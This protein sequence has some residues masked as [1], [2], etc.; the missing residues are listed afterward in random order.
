MTAR[1]SLALLPLLLAACS[2]GPTVTPDAG[3]AP[4]SGVEPHD[5]GEAPHDAGEAPHDAGVGPAACDPALSV[6]RAQVAVKALDLF[7]IVASGGTGAYRFTLTQ[8]ASGAIVNALSGAYL[9]GETTGVEDV[10]TVTDDGCEGS[11]QVTLRV[12]QPLLLRPTTVMATP[13]T[14]WRFEVEGG[15]GRVAFAMDLAGSGGAVTEAGEYTAG[16]SEGLDRV[17]V[18]DLES[19]E[20]AEAEVTVRADARMSVVPPVVLVPMGQPFTLGFSGGS[21]FV[22]IVETPTRFALQGGRTVVGTAPGREQVTARD[23]FTGETTT[24]MVGVGAPHRFAPVRSGDGLF[25]A[26]M[27][28]PGDLDG[29]GFPDVLLAQPEADVG[30]VNS[31]AVYVYRGSATGVAPVAAQVLPGLDRRE[32][33]GRAMAVADFDHDGRLDLAVGAPRA[34]SAGVD[35]GVVRIYR[36]AAAGLFEAQPWLTLPG[37]FAADNFGWALAACDFNDDGHMDLAVGSFNSE[38]RD[39]TPQAGNQGGVAI[40]FGHDRGLPTEATRTLWG[41]LPDGSGGWVGQANLHLGIALAAG[42]VDGDGVC[43]LVAGTYE[44]DQDTN[45]NDGL[46]YVYR[47]LRADGEAIG[48]P[49]PRPALAWANLDP[50]DLGGSLARNLAVAD[51]DGDDRAEVIVSHHGFDAGSGDSHGALRVFRGQPM[52]APVSALSPARPADWQYEHDGSADQVGFYPVVADATGDGR[53]DLLVGNLADEATGAPADS[54]TVF[55]FEGR[56]AALPETTPT[57][58]LPGDLAG[59]R[60]GTALTV[61][62]DLDGDRRPEWVVLAGY[63]DLYGPDYGVPLYVPGDAAAPRAPLELESAA[64]GAQFGWDAAVVGD[65]T[66]DGLEDLVVGA[67]ESGVE[68]LGR[69]TG[70]AYLYPGAADGFATEPALSLTQALR[71]SA[72]DRFGVGVAPAGDFDGDGTPDFAVV[73]RFEDQPSSFGSTYAPEASCAGAGTDVG[74]VYVFSGVTSG[75][76]SD[77]PIFL[78]F[79]PLAGDGLRAIDGGFDYDGDGFDD[80]ILGNLEFDPAGGTNAGGVL[81]IRGRARDAQG[82]TV[83]RCAPDFQLMGGVANDQLGLAVTAV[84]D[85]DGDGCDEVAAGA[86]FEDPTLTN[87]GTVRVIFGWGGAGCPA[88]PQMVVLRAGLANA[89]GGRGLGG[90]GD[91]D[92]D[93]VPD[94]AVGLPGFAQDGNTVGAAGLISGAYVVGLPRE[95]AQDATPPQRV[96]LMFDA[97]RPPAVVGGTTPGEELGRSA[98][99]VDLGAP[100]G[101]VVVAGSPSGDL[102]GTTLAGGARGFAWQAGVGLVAAPLLGFAGEPARP[103][104]RLGEWVRGGHR[105]GRGVLLVGGYDG[106]GVVTDAGS[107]YSFDVSP[108]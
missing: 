54:G 82:R 100:R 71:Q 86:P 98:T 13:G 25:D 61:V 67:P 84:G 50:A 81:L 10:V 35:I 73:S 62:P 96:L 40:Y 105:G 30:A 41:D 7:T 72:F 29:D 3:V 22:D 26:K 108:P 66:G 92:G 2:G 37:R 16:A 76:P 99:L 52:G 70:A 33:Q 65:V 49:E 14:G 20:V 95:P 56:A 39:R 18:T 8:D 51:L 89:Q 106:S 36:G 83:V 48:G 53:P 97:A 87:E 5:A 102:A 17:V 23:R 85:L 88:S 43:D 45:T 4:D 107:L 69:L 27:S 15:S 31:G 42:D 9:S 75:V 74:A 104:G 78:Y 12:V 64:S 60:F 11:V 58:V 103:G 21:G 90:G 46:V 94:L 79:G 44:F 59:D 1:R 80:L 32:E 68:A 19:R 63:A 57:T 47:S 6:E 93:G 24:L 101:T 55:V 91:A 28:S 34:D 38:D 77:V